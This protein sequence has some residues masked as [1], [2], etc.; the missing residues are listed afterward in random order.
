MGT[1]II[2]SC[3][4]CKKVREG[5]SQGENGEESWV[6]LRTYRAKY[7]VEEREFKLSHTYCPDCLKIYGPLLASAID[8]SSAL[9]P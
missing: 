7:Q 4:F 2:A 9:T 5:P 8:D 3:C 6:S 1:I